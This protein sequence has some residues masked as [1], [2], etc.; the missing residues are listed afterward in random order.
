[1]K[2]KLKKYIKLTVKPYG[3][4]KQLKNKCKNIDKYVYTSKD[5]TIIK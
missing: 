3:L 2:L 4:R 5:S 1:M